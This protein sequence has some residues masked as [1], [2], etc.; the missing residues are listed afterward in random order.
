M[1]RYRM[2]TAAVL[3]LALGA[4]SGSESLEGL[5]GPSEENGPEEVDCP[6][7]ICGTVTYQGIY[8]GPSVRIYVRAYQSTDSLSGNPAAAVGTPDFATYI[9]GPGA[10]RLDVGAYRGPVT[11]SAFMDVDGSGD[12]GGPNGWAESLHGLHSDPLGA[13][14]GYTFEGDE[15]SVPRTINVGEEGLAGIDIALEDSGVMSGVI[16]GDHEGVM[17]VGAFEPKVGGAFL[18]HTEYASYADGITYYVAAPAKSDWRVRASVSG[19]TGFFPVNPP[20][21][22]PANTQPVEVVANTI[23][24]GIDIQLP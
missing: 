15:Q 17:V 14:G 7:A 4:C 24:E 2:P 9:D 19:T 5:D 16:H 20:P 3:T 10:F 8:D 11:V 18:H 13:H 22:P 6:H 1:K 23:V 12:A 21:A